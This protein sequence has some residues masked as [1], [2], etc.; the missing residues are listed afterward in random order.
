MCILCNLQLKRCR[1]AV[2]FTKCRKVKT[3]TKLI[4]EV[5]WTHNSCNSKTSNKTFRHS[6]SWFWSEWY[7]YIDIANRTWLVLRP[8]NTFFWDHLK[9]HGNEWQYRQC[10]QHR[11][12]SCSSMREAGEADQQPDQAES[13][14]CGFYCWQTRQLRQAVCTGRFC[15]DWQ[16]LSL[17][18][19]SPV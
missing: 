3:F 17:H 18:V 4:S 2:T 10:C 11:W 6:A 19:S 15:S 14:C 5:A 9:A 7:I 1:V 16:L 8:A 12:T 13:C